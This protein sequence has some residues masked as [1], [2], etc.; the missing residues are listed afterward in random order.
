MR[1]HLLQLMVLS[2]LFAT[3]VELI[4]LRTEAQ[5]TQAQAGVPMFE[6]DPSWLKMPEGMKF[7]SPS[8]LAV[9]SQDHVWI[10]NQ[11]ADPTV[12]TPLKDNERPGS[13]G[14]RA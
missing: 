8:G 3:A 6:V 2:L 12:A 10:V 5:G 7:G 9:D 14:R 1:R 11:R 4:E 13:S